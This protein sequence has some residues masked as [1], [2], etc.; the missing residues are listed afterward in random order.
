MKLKTL[1]WHIRPSR[2]RSQ[3]D[4]PSWTLCCSQTEPLVPPKHITGCGIW[5]A[6]RQGNTVSD[7]ITF[8]MTPLTLCSPAGLCAVPCR[9]LWFLREGSFVNLSPA[10]CDFNNVTHSWLEER[11]LHQGSSE[12]LQTTRKVPLHLYCEGKVGFFFSQV[13]SSS[14]GP[15]CNHFQLGGSSH[16]LS[17][18]TFPSF[19]SFNFIP[20]TLGT[21][22]P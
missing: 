4:F 19:S 21:I 10:V 12:G 3:P 22:Y 8:H 20:L 7:T 1:H 2:N 6:T 11:G 13:T 17:P 5:W 16:Q 14:N 18:Y 9:W 15:E